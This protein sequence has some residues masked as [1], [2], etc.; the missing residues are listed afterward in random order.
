MI[1][2][3]QVD[4]AALAIKE[5]RELDVAEKAELD[6]AMERAWASLPEQYQWLK[7]W[8]YV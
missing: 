4:N 5:R 2:S 7:D 6:R 3:Q 1:S 8:Q